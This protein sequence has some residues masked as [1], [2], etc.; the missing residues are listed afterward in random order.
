MHVQNV[1][2]VCA[3]TVVDTHAASGAL[4][5]LPLRCASMHSTGSPR[6]WG[7]ATRTHARAAAF[8]L[9]C[10]PTLRQLYAAPPPPPPASPPPPPQQQLQQQAQRAGGGRGPHSKRTTMTMAPMPILHTPCAAAPV[11]RAP[12]SQHRSPVSSR[13]LA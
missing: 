7:T 11:G 2:C 8:F 6:V 3:I 10:T 13:G 5:C 1:S 12:L 9:R 4:R